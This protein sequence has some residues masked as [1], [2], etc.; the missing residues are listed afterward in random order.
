MKVNEKLSNEK[1]KKVLTPILEQKN[2][3]LRSKSSKAII[4]NNDIYEESKIP[5]PGRGAGISRNNN[6]GCGTTSRNNNLDVTLSGEYL[7]I[8]ERQLKIEVQKQQMKIKKV[9]DESLKSNAKM[10]KLQ[11]LS[12][13]QIKVLI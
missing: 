7:A 6:L 12:I 3:K 5:S 4:P 10:S 9:I 13:N 2:K 8:N 1:K 11:G